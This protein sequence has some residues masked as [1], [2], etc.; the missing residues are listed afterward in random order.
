[1]PRATTFDDSIV[2]QLD[3]QLTTTSNQV[4]VRLH[5]DPSSYEAEV[6]G[7]MLWFVQVVAVH[8]TIDGQTLAHGR[9]LQ[10][11]ITTYSQ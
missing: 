6:G 1:M 9:A 7:A 11:C 4:L 2:V 10:L 5:H 3:D 8:E